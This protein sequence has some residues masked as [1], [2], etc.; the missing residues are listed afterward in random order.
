MLR[1]WGRAKV[2]VRHGK[3]IEGI[4]NDWKGPRGEPEQKQKRIN[5]NKLCLKMME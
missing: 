2:H 5:K 4:G 1:K 3:I